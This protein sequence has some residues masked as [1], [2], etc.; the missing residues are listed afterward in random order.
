MELRKMPQQMQRFDR[1]GSPLDDDEDIIPDGGR[2]RVPMPF[3]D[4]HL[5]PEVRRAF[6][7]ADQDNLDPQGFLRGHRPG[8]APTPKT[9]AA[10]KAYENRSQRLQDAWK[11]PAPV[12]AKPP[13]PAGARSSAHDA[14]AAYER[15]NKWLQNA[16]RTPT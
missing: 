4:H 2:I 6:G 13:A 3:M 14:G 10:I 5:S 11:H 9:D 16:W 15:R 12:Q 1:H 8:F 7:L